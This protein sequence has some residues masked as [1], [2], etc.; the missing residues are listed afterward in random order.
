MKLY[1]IAEAYQSLE[2]IE[3]DEDVKKVLDSIGDEFDQKAENIVYV[4]KDYETD[5]EALRNEEKRLTDKR[6]SLDKRKKYLV[7]YL[8]NN[9][10]VTGR[11]KIKAG[12]FDLRI[13]KNPWAVKVLDESLID[14][15]YFKIK[16]E[17]DKKKIKEDIENG[18]NVVG[19]E[20]VQGEGLR[21][22]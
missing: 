3:A 18:I 13:Q 20:L 21:I 4:I 14:G 8:Y 16:K 19:A 2:S 17:I 6:R 5:M 15:D 7:D 1:E 9:M 10:K 11:E 12:T 22:K